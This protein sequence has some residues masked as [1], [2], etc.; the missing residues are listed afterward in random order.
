MKSI[1]SGGI[2]ALAVLWAAAPGAAPAA[3][4]WYEGGTLQKA[5]AAEWARAAPENQLASAADFIAALNGVS[6][7]ASVKDAAA[8]ADIRKRAAELQAC[9]N[10]AIADES[11]A[12]Q[13]RKVA[14][15]VVFCTVMK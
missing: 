2:A 14:E 7:I 10:K 15:M 3:E 1:N 5:T 6:D 12:R 9:V 13:D 11:T 8:L 4:A